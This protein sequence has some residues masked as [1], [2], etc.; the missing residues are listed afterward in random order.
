MVKQTINSVGVIGLGLIGASVLKDIKRHVPDVVRYGQSEG[1]E[2]EI[3]QREGLIEPITDFEAFVNACD[4]VIIATPI[5]DVV[6]IA[7]RIKVAKK[8]ANH[9]I[10]IDVASVKKTIVP[11]FNKLSNEKVTFIPTHPMG[12]SEKSGYQAARGGLFRQKPWIICTKNRNDTDVMAISD[13]LQECCGVSV[14]FLQPSLHDKYVAAASHAVIDISHFLFDFINTK[15]PEALKVAGE[16][17]ITTT[18]LASDNPKMLAGIH[19]HNLESIESIL[20]EFLEFA[21]TKVDDLE[22]LDIEYFD[23]NK[24]ARDSWLHHRNKLQ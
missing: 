19:K 4:L 6:G 14:E 15:H 2:L 9:L 11:V 13:L 23:N 21:N 12:G 24:I 22:N 7:K 18:R 1:R 8:S 10:V 16:S 3:A 5:D 17:F 20:K